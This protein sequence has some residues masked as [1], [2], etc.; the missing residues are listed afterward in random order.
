MSP[1]FFARVRIPGSGEYEAMLVLDQ[2]VAD[3]Q[4][5][6]F[7]WVI[8]AEDKAVYRPVKLGPL[9][10]GLR[11]VREGLKADDRVVIKGLMAVRNGVKVNPQPSEMV[12]AAEPA[13]KH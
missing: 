6:S 8:D 3:D 10:D 12:A 2:A 4:G 11:V 9:V 1:G 5:S 7:V 13:P